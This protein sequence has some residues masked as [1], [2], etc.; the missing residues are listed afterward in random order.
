MNDRTAYIKGLR[1]LADT[2][3][4]NPES[5]PLPYEGDSSRMTFHFLGGDESRAAMAA[6]ARAIPCDWRKRVVEHD[7]GT[8]YFYLDG[9]LHGLNLQLVAFRESVCERIVTGTR[10]VTEKVKDPEALAQVPEVEVTKVVEDVRWECHPVLAPA[11]QPEG[12]EAA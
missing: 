8:A 3:E 7:D 5:I 11:A 4:A 12:P 2:L 1:E 10:E 6:A 9:E